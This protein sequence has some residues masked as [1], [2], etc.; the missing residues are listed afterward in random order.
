MS[1]VSFL[2]TDIDHDVTLGGNYISE[3]VSGGNYY[4]VMVMSQ[5]GCLRG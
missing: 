2:V 4:G 5:S 3:L 1:S